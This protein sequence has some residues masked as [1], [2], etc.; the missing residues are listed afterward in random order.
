MTFQGVNLLRFIPFFLAALV[1]NGYSAEL[2]AGDAVRVLPTGQL[3][4]DSRL[5]PLKHLKEYFPFH[6]PPT[7]EKWEARRDEL[8]RR[9]LVA[10]GLWPMLRPTPLNPV[11]HGRTERDGFTVD[12]VYFESIPGHYVTGLL[13]RPKQIEGKIPAI[14]CPHGHGGRLQDH[15]AQKIR[16]IIA[17][18]RE[19]FESSGRFPKLARCAHLARMGCV[20][21][22]YDMVGYADSQQIPRKVVHAPRRSR[23]HLENPERWGFSTAQA[24]MRLQNTLGLQ[25]YNSIR[26]LDFLSSLPEVD[27]DRLAVTGSSGGGTQTFLVCAVDPRP[28]AA[29]PQ[30]MVSTSMQGGCLCENACLLRIGTGNVELAALFAPKPMAMTAAGDW[31]RDMMTSGFPELQQ[32]YGMYGVKENVA[33]KKLV[34]LPHNYNYVTRALMYRWF[35]KHLGLGLEDPV[36]EEDFELLSEQERTVWSEEHPAPVRRGEEYEVSIIK[37]WD[38]ESRQLLSQLHPQDADSLLEYRNVVGG[39]W[40]SIIGRPLPSPG[41]VTRRKIT[42]HDRG[43]FLEMTD[44]IRYEARGEELPVIWLYPQNREWNGHLVIW[45]DGKGKQALYSDTGVPRDEVGHLLAHG[46]AVAGLDLLMQGEFLAEAES[47]HETRMVKATRAAAAFTFGYN[48]TLFVRRVH[49]IMSLVAWARDDGR[50]SHVHLVGVDGAGPLVAAAGSQLGETV[51]RRVVDA[52]GFRFRDIISVRDPQ[53]VPGAV[54]YGDLPG[55]LSLSA[56]QPM[57]VLGEAKDLPDIV[58]AA[59]QASSAPTNLHVMDGSTMDL[60]QAAFEIP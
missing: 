40:E 8:R 43:D 33:C 57:W 13:F 29:F 34:H 6:V 31:T 14:L 11:I 37:W 36:L 48:D 51:E 9:V 56:P 12:K 52:Q 24:D 42:K 50:T 30:G 21:F 44:L 32:L 54:K 41:D 23:P 49:D 55:M 27:T 58:Q 35:N 1:W 20:A 45:V 16:Q 46:Y 59:Y 53:F 28:M 3:P 25:L 18:G 17:E 60:V 4:E 5:Q 39:A 26:G 10:A 7:V 38:Q 2:L 22:I 15:G 19:R 47:Y